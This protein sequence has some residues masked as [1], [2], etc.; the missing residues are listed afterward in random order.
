M[1][2]V[3]VMHPA[4]CFLEILGSTLNKQAKPLTSALLSHQ[5]ADFVQCRF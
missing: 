3:I 2:P 4:S 5:V 1:Y